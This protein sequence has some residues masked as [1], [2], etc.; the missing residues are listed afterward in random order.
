MP[1]LRPS[2]VKRMRRLAARGGPAAHAFAYVAEVAEVAAPPNP[3]QDP[4]YTTPPA[5]V[6]P[7]VTLLSPTDAETDTV[8][9]VTY[10]GRVWR[11]EKATAG[12]QN[13]GGAGFRALV[14]PNEP[15]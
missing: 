11:L 5:P 15:K 6:P 7:P 4:P 1:K 8:Y 9:V 10:T 2:F 12:K 14:V 13:S 3:V